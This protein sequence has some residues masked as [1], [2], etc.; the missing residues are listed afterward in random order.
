MD[1]S[2]NIAILGNC[3]TD[4]ITKA[5]V[6]ACGNYHIAAEIYN[7]P[8]RQYNQ[9]IINPGS[10]FYKSAPEL[11][12]L[13]LEGKNLFP[14]WFEFKTI[15]NSREQK[16]SSV[17]SILESL[18]S[19]AEEI[20]KNSGTKI[21]V[22]N[23]K[24]PH[25]S[26]LGILDN[27]YFPGLRD[28]IS[29]LNY[30]LSEWAADKDY[31]YI[32]DYHAFSAY[33]GE[34]NLEDAKML[35]MTK[36]TISLKYTTALAREYMKYILPLKYRAKKCLVL[37]LDNTLWGGIAGEDGI[38]GVKLDITDS[39]RSF[40]DFQK[41]I[42]NLYYKGV[43]LAINSKNNVEDAMNIIEN[44]PHMLLKKEYFSVMKIN[45]QDKAKNLT[46][47]AEE[48][49]ISTDSIIFFDDSIVERELVKSLLPEVMVVDVPVD[50]SK[51]SDTIRNLIEFEYLKLT[52]EDLSRNVMYTANKKRDEAQK[53]FS[54][55]EEYL[56][57]L[58][59]KVIL[60]FS[61]DFT[62]P[63]IA[64]LTQK[65]NQFNLTTKRYTQEEITRFH[66]SPDYIVASVQV[67]DI[68]GDNGITGVCIVKLE[69]DSAF[70]DTFLLSC[71]IMGRDVE[72]AF[73]SKVVELLRA[74]GVKT[75][76]A[77]YRKTERNQTTADFYMKAGFSVVSANESET[78]Y[79][80][81]ESAQ[82][83]GI[84]QIETIVKGEIP[85][86]TKNS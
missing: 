6:Q 51:Y 49:N 84:E 25:F 37:D 55:V 72:F 15:M 17:Q 2:I 74:Q 23:F 10:G 14:E 3:T 68:Y 11:T 28:M 7:C 52:A 26:P 35:Y 4:Y 71:R 45:W 41:E 40:Y 64:Q 9:E 81:D 80:L 48:L 56:N 83:G 12:I 58:Q 46:E 27:K 24:I 53:K 77:L 13:F 76:D 54:T 16:L 5:L 60:E 33:Y 82:P 85:L 66:Q 79:R 43:I 29:L 78:S 65:T 59:T 1:D 69:G 21:L 73:L 42:L 32:F 22:N 34:A 67:T 39:G 86:W 61:N 18:I 20:H 70:I 62:I 75:V 30:Q 57:S 63:R 8:Y 36:T 38:S 19:L 31:V 44:H 47:I 50:T